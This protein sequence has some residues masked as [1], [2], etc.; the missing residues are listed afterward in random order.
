MKNLFFLL[1]LLFSL[2]SFGDTISGLT[3]EGR[4]A[5]KIYLPKDLNAKDKWPLIISLHGFLSNPKIQNKIFPAS[6]FVDSKGFILVTPYGKRNAVGIRY[7]NASEACCDLFHQNPDD[8]GY[9][10][11]LIAKV[12]ENYSIGDVFLVGHSNGGFL[13]YR[14]A[15]EASDLISGIVSISGVNNFDQISCH[16]SKAISI[17]QIHGTSDRVI[18]YEGNTKRNIPS[19]LQSITPWATL[20]HC[21]NEKLSIFSNIDKE[22]TSMGWNQCSQGKSVLLW[23][24]K[25]RKHNETLGNNLTNKIIDTLFL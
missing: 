14:F 24:V 6:N 2:T 3:V 8:I 17:L 13:A 7:W 12:K 25:N 23:S 21:N 9:L 20:N 15:C 16:P 1:V 11:K 18:K 5:A 19:A 22:I 10:K 4:R